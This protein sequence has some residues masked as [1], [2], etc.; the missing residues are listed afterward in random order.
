[1]EKYISVYENAKEL[2][3]AVERAK[4]LSAD[5]KSPYAYVRKWFI[6]QFPDYEIVPKSIGL[7]PYAKINVPKKPENEENKENK[8]DDAA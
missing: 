6:K 4:I 5:A 3:E 8:N 1:M 7:K 2:E